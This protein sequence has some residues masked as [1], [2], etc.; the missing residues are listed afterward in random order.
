MSHSG[1][2]GMSDKLGNSGQ[3]ELEELGLEEEVHQVWCLLQDMVLGYMVRGTPLGSRCRPWEDLEGHMDSPD[4]GLPLSKLG[5]S[6]KSGKS[7]MSDMSGKSGKSDSQGK[8]IIPIPLALCHII[9]LSKPKVLGNAMG[10]NSATAAREA[11]SGNTQ[12]H[13]FKKLGVVTAA[14][15][16]WPNK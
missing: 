16:P 8:G 14:S 5:N 10:Y 1:N 15:G 3:S 2:S 6:G 13:R 11:R 7:G 4:L 12:T 9:S